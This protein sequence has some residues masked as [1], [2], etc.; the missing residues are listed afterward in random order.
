MATGFD[1]VTIAEQMAG[2]AISS[3]WE[4]P[5]IARCERDSRVARVHQYP[6]SG[7]RRARVGDFIQRSNI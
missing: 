2:F 5:R 3:E 7:M 4:R 6:V 1:V